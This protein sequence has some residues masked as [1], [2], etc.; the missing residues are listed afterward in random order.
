MKYTADLK[1]KRLSGAVRNK[2]LNK[3][4]KQEK[5]KQNMINNLKMMPG[6]SWA[7]FN[8][9]VN[10]ALP[11]VHKK[12]TKRDNHNSF[13]QEKG[14]KGNNS[15]LKNAKDEDSKDEENYDENGNERGGKKKRKRENSPDP[16]AHLETKKDRPKFGEIADR[17]PD[18]RV[19]TKL[20][21]NVPKS[22]GSMAR[23]YILQTEREKIIEGYRA[24]MEKKKED[25]FFNA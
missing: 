22:A 1:E 4:E 10:N 18:L 3:R 5:E 9:R 15:D 8:R 12:K 17:P 11:L 24:L 16:W 7:D 6:E 25:A 21:N 20:L 13:F 14:K 2:P 19:P 23:R